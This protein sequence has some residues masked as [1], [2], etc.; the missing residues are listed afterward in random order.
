MT[1]KSLYRLCALTLTV[2][3]C[4]V[5][6][7][8]L[9]AAN[10]K[11]QAESDMERGVWLYKHENYEE[12]LGMFK[13]AKE[14][15]PGSPVVEYYIGMTYKQLQDFSSAKPHLEAALTL[16]PKEAAALPE[17]V[18]LL[19][20]TDQIDE[21]KKWLEEHDYKIDIE[22]ATKPEEKAMDTE[23][24]KM[25]CPECGFE[26]APDEKG[27]CPKCGAMMK[28]PEKDGDGKGPPQKAGRVLSADNEAKLRAALSAIQGI[29]EQVTPPLPD[30]DF[31][32]VPEPG[33]PAT[34]ES[35]TKPAESTAGKPTGVETTKPD[36]ST[37][38]YPV[39]AAAQAMI[40]KLFDAG[41]QDVKALAK[42]AV[43]IDQQLKSIER[44]RGRRA[45]G[46]LFRVTR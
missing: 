40:E 43:M 39:Q 14:G 2:V 35:P 28:D 15:E 18:S 20:Q 42:L 12:A 44:S 4:V 5:I 32:P 23:A 22:P 6:F 1:R 38:L 45:L 27:K 30:S 34:A 7:H 41:P 26:G 16:E 37:V 46:K 21:A 3:I 9:G 11:G 33:E 17:L 24:E 25:K 36:G 13:K 10:G 31:K 8:D 19:H 29:L